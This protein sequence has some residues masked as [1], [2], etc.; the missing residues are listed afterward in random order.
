MKKWKKGNIKYLFGW[1]SFEHDFVEEGATEPINPSTNLLAEEP[2][3]GNVVWNAKVSHL[4][5]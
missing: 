1:N 5:A 2:A 3:N 4:Y